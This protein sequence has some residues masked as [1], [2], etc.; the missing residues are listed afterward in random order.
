M[1]ISLMCC[2]PCGAQEDPVL[3][4][5][6]PK[7]NPNKMPHVAG[8]YSGEISFSAFCNG[9]IKNEA[10][11]KVMSFTLRVEGGQFDRIEQVKGNR[12]PLTFCEQLFGL[13]RVTIF[14]TEIFAVDETGKVFPLTNMSLLLNH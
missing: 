11:W 9:E 4:V 7:P 3:R 6:K 5:R 1:V 2:A 10:G 13:K 12:I 14:I 8:V